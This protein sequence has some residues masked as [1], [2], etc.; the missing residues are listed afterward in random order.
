MVSADVTMCYLSKW[1]V[2]KDH[3]AIVCIVEIKI[4][5]YKV[6]LMKQLS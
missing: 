3:F 4:K 5:M 2:C 6:C 1:K